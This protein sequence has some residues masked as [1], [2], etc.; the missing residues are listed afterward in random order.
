MIPVMGRPLLERRLEKL[1][2][3]GI[4]E[5]V[6]NPCYQGEKITGYFGDG[7]RFG[8]NIRYEPEK[9]APGTG[10]TIRNTRH[11]FDESFFVFNADILCDFSLDDMLRYHR[12][13]KAD[14]TIAATYVKDPTAYG[15]IEYDSKGYVTRFTEKPKPSQVRSHYINA[16]I[17]IFEPHVLD[18]IPDRKPLSVQVHPDDDYA[19]KNEKQNGKTEMWYIIDCNAV[20]FVYL[21]V[22]RELHKAEARQALENGRFLD[23]LEKVPV[24]PGE[25]YLVEAGTVHAIGEGILLAEVQ[26]SS[27][28]TYRLYDFRRLGADGKPRELHIEK[29]LDV[30]R[31]S[32]SRQAPPQN[33]H[34]ACCS[35]FVVNKLTVKGG[36]ELR[37]TED[38]S[39]PCWYW[40]GTV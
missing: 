26:Q 10:G 6:L 23:L 31:L 36:M 5:I 33:E 32:P 30:M 27:N 9:E 22:N 8:W 18:G 38:P 12:K 14:I 29:A 25:S 4:T 21:G 11:H 35:H 7:R 15:V 16:G 3:C 20:A 1:K 17:Y 34:L 39:P 24:C 13:Q 40:R 2:E 19:W 28:L 37:V